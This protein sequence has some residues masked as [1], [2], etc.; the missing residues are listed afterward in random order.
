MGPPLMDE[1][2]YCAEAFSLIT[3]RCFQVA[4]RQDGQAGWPAVTFSNE[5]A[6]RRFRV[7]RTRR[8]AGRRGPLMGRVAASGTASL[9]VVDGLAATRSW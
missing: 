8:P 2:H 7:T 1:A 4:S 9:D 6:P 3:G 5:N